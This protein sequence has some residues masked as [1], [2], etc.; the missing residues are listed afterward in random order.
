MDDYILVK[1]TGRAVEALCNISGEYRQHV[2]LENGKQVLYLRFK[3]AL[4]GCIQSAILW[5]DT[6]KGCL[7][8]MGF[9]LNKYDPCVTNK[10]VNGKQCTIC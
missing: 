4:Y 5:Y 1:F 8:D 10:V 3:K 9:K 7:I 6:F 2:T